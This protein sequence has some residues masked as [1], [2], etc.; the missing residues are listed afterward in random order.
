MNSELA[1][2][3]LKLYPYMSASKLQLFILCIVYLLFLFSFLSTKKGGFLASTPYL[4]LRTL[5]SRQK[6]FFFHFFSSF[7][8][9][10]VQK[11][12]FKKKKER[13]KK[14]KKRN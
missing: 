11:K 5:N 14:R 2:I 6:V 10:G 9:Y 7:S 3:E 4:F 12:G 8:F 1:L 13:A